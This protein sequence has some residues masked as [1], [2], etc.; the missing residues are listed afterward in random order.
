MN[1][2]T[3]IKVTNKDRSGSHEP[4]KCDGAHL[5]LSSS[6]DPL[7][8]CWWS[9]LVLLNSSYQDLSNAT[10]DVVIGASCTSR[11]SF[12]FFYLSPLSSQI[13]RR[14]QNKKERKNI[15]KR[16]QKHIKTLMM[17]PLVPSEISDEAHLPLNDS[18]GPF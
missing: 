8:H 7:C 3:P 9:S 14:R 10:D 13:T 2:T 15:K 12:F 4:C 11:V 5:P 6:C 16:P 17:T 18:Y 1:L